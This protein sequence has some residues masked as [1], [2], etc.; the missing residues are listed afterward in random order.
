MKIE[1]VYVYAT[2]RDDGL[3]FAIGTTYYEGNRANGS[4]ALFAERSD[5]LEFAAT[6]S[7]RE[8]ARLLILPTVTGGEGFVQTPSG[9]FHPV[10]VPR[11][12]S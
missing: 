2:S 9:G 8:G 11:E 6:L 5:A 1:T 7:K 10:N 3:N 4:Y 12:D